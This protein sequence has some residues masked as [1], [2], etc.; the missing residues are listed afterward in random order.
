MKTFAG[1][2]RVT[3]S[4]DD[5]GFASESGS[6]V[7]PWRHFK[8][9]H[10]D[11]RNVFLF[12]SKTAAIVIPTKGISAAAVEFM[13]DHVPPNRSGRQSAAPAA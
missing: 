9:S 7:V 12:L 5:L 2:A 10:R 1:S 8:A 4:E 13:M 3:L 11:S 6:H